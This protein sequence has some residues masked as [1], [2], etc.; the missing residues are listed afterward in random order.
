MTPWTT[1]P[2]LLFPG[3]SSGSQL[4]THRQQSL[5]EK[6][7]ILGHVLKSKRKPYYKANGDLLS[8]CLKAFSSSPSCLSHQNI[9]RLY[10]NI[11]SIKQLTIINP[12]VSPKLSVTRKSLPL[13]WKPALD[14]QHTSQHPSTSRPTKRYYHHLAREFLPCWSQKRICRL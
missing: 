3:G 10:Y 7:E 14:M 13:T 11:N 1:Y 4:F 12:S 5:F 8:V 6:P 9:N 2:A